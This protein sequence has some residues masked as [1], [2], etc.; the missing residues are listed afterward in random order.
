MSFKDNSLEQIKIEEEFVD[1]HD[2]YKRLLQAA[3][4]DAGVKGE[5]IA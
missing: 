4:N 1:C 2:D 3:F 5:R